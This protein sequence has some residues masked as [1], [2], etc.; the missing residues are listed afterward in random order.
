MTLDYGVEELRSILERARTAA[1]GEDD[2][3]RL[4]AVITT[5][6]QL[7]SE[8]EKK[9]ASVERLRALLF[10][11]HTETTRRV[12]GDAAAGGAREVGAA[13]DAAGRSKG[14]GR[15]GASTYRGAVRVKVA[16]AGLAKGA[17]CP[18]CSRGK[19]YLQGEP[20]TRVRV[21]A[22]APL[23]ATVYELERWR[24]NLCGEVFTAPTP[25]G[26]GEDKY[27]E[28]VA[29]MVA[30]LKYGAGVPLHRL[31][32]LQASLGIP[33]P[34]ATAWDLV[35]EAAAGATPAFGELVATAAQGEVLYHDDTGAKV[36]SLGEGQ[37]M[38][39]DD[40]QDERTGIFTSAIVSK[41][42]EHEISLFF[43]GRQHAGEN[44]GEVLKERAAE[45]T[46]P[47]QMCDAAARNTSCELDTILAHCIAHARRRFV[48]VAE[49]FPAECRVVL[50]TL[51]EVYRTDAQARAQGL[52]PEQ[53]LCLHQTE[54]G[55]RMEG[56]KSFL[57]ALLDERT[58]EPN[59]GLGEAIRYMLK[60]WQELTLFL[61]SPGAPLDNN[62]A[63]RT[64]KRA[65]LHRKNALFFKT[66][67]GARVADLF[68]SLIHTAQRCGADPFDYLVALQRHHREVAENPGQWLPWCYRE[69][70][71]PLL[72]AS[73]QP[74]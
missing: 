60:H 5:L 21:M 15:N 63:E 32:Q 8:L 54:S 56:L 29:A 7:T 74:P 64:L 37:A 65:I 41:V 24:C 59:S 69:T 55:P 52:S 46:P 38:P 68:M 44:L 72:E 61:R 4:E 35:E 27:D 9:G 18:S 36:L 11:P 48:T 3:A 17:H 47:I 53:R 39:A 58:V 71:A 20:A 14:H 31:E 33:L 25:E 22:M 73:P 26:V 16:H 6:A 13:S 67:N 40:E 30:L 2:I 57:E 45:L 28:T 1:L 10:G 49:H 62:I 66:E 51:R 23:A 12:F 19:V 42:G 70:L 43:T 34:A 50:E